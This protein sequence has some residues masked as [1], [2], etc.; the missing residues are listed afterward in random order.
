[1]MSINNEERGLNHTIYDEKDLEGGY[2]HTEKDMART[3]IH[4]S[5]F[6]C[7]PLIFRIEKKEEKMI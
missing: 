3:I 4:S 7:Y 1:M 6:E 2:V 5:P